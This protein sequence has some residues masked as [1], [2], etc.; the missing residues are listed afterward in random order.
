MALVVA[1]FLAPPALAQHIPP[2]SND[3]HPPSNQPAYQLPSPLSRPGVPQYPG[4]AHSNDPHFTRTEPRITWPAP[5]PAP[6]TRFPST[7]QQ[8]QRPPYSYSSPRGTRPKAEAKP[9]K[10]K[11]ANLEQ[12][13]AKWDSAI[14]LTQAA[15]ERNCRRL[16]AEG[17]VKAR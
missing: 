5:G 17:R 2:H 3:P 13:Y 11:A 15:W 4:A 1:L 6:D 16:A 9:H 12:C 14:G 10:A 8:Y 7:P